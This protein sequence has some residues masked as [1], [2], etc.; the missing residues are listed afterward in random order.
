MPTSMICIGGQTVVVA[1]LAGIAAE[2]SVEMLLPFEQPGV[3]A[4][5]DH[6]AVK[7][8]GGLREFQGIPASRTVSIKVETSGD[9]M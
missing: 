6:L 4:G 8:V 5:D 9:S 2:K 1:R 3:A 7:I